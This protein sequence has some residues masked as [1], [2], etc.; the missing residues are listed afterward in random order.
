M[1][2]ILAMAMAALILLCWVTAVSETTVRSETYKKKN[3]IRYYFTDDDGKLTEG[4][5]GAAIL[6]A[7]FDGKRKWPS[8]IRYLA[9][10]GT[11]MMNNDGYSVVKLEYDKNRQVTKITLYDD[12]GSTVAIGSGK[13]CRINVKYDAEGNIASVYYG[14]RKNKRQETTEEE[15]LLYRI[16]TEEGHPFVDGLPADELMEG[17]QIRPEVTATPT[18]TPDRKSVV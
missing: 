12:H 2:R 14:D 11:R 15:E 7:L 10:D 3:T 5:G 4:P 17:P 18:P 8:K 1:K 13:Y 16:V 9:A 6:E